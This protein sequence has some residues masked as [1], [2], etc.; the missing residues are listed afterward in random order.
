MKPVCTAPVENARMLEHGD[1]ERQVRPDPENGERSQGRQRSRD[2]V[3]PRF[4]V[5]GDLRDERIVVDADAI[6]LDHPGVDP[7]AGA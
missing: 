3:L 4:G 7:H 2:R 1:E 5:N 6:A